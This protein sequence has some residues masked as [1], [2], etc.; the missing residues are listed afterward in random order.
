M[1]SGVSDQFPVDHK[2]KWCKC[3]IYSRMWNIKYLEGMFLPCTPCHTGAVFALISSVVLP[4]NPNPH[5]SMLVIFHS[6][7]S[8]HTQASMAHTTIKWQL[9]EKDQTWDVTCNNSCNMICILCF[10]YFLNL[11]TIVT[12]NIILLFINLFCYFF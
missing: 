3:R 11:I 5:T 2:Q 6:L 7:P 12:Q 10:F 9:T 1:S 4:T 8:T